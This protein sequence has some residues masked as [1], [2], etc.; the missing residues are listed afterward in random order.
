MSDI[1]HT[2]DDKL[3]TLEIKK[4]L[5]MY[6][7]PAIVGT[8]LASLYNIIDR[9]Y[10]GQG[11]GSMAISG[12]ALTF[13]FMNFLT[14]FSMLIGAGAASR[15]SIRLGEGDRNRAEQILGNALT[16][17][18]IISVAVITFSL[19]FMNPILILFGGSDNTLKYAKEFMQIIVPGTILSA[20]L[21]GFNNI[22]R[23]SGYPK[24]A[25][26]TMLISAVIDVTLAPVFIF[27]FK[28]G[29]SGA[30]HATNIAFF[31]GTIWVLLHF[32]NKNTNI[33][34]HRK[35]LKLDRNIV[36]SILNIG[37]SPFSMQL[38]A[39]ITVVLMNRALIKQ[40]GDLAMG[41]LG[42]Q[43]GIFTLIVMFIVG[44]NQGVQPIVG[45]NFGARQFDRM[46]LALKRT[47][48][49]A[50]IVST[51]GFILGT[52]FPHALAS[53]F[54]KDEELRG[55]AARAIRISVFLYPLIGSQIVFTNF[56]QSIGKARISMLLSLTRQVL[57][58]IPCL[59][60][61]PPIFGLDGVWASMPVADG[62]AVIVTTT[63]LFVFIK[64][65]KREQMLA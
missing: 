64:R 33:R 20:L 47:A 50:T 49:T 28:M 35:N 22:M 42:I 46:F 29:I 59:I 34:F 58:L 52:F 38:A 23:A 16:L 54:T 37:M 60:L 7:V 61:L 45:F 36:K 57:F 63:T 17:T 41:A 3:G 24:K 26:I 13:P 43:N 39:S 11:V 2:V 18:F 44:L 12:L 4:L 25:M 10:I 56:F 48:V 21:F 6:S 30:A 40:G 53:V 62:L 19:V 31:I 55:M 5:W 8:L 51:V 1:K 32:F 15:I 9:V 27:V 14:A 65:F